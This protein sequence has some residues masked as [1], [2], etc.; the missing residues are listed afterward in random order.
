M[1]MNTSGT[2]RP[3]T[4]NPSVKKAKAIMC[5]ALRSYAGSLALRFWNG[6]TVELGAGSPRTTVIF[7]VW[8][9]FA[10]WCYIDRDP[11]RLAKFL[12]MLDEADT[13]GM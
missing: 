7:R 10:N 1:D 11:L 9:R 3:R 12:R 2:S 6:E 8:D 5:R 13:V 4:E